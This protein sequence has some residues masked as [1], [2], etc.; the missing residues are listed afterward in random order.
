MTLNALIINVGKLMAALSL[1][2]LAWLYLPRQAAATLPAEPT[3]QRQT[4]EIGNHQAKS[5][6]AR[7]RTWQTITLAV[8]GIAIAGQLMETIQTA[9]AC[10]LLANIRSSGLNEPPSKCLNSE[11]IARG[12]T[13]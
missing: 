5:D 11:L 8:E 10:Q 12:Y 9:A 2:T 3:A 7:T 13:R 4:W 1:S 6:P